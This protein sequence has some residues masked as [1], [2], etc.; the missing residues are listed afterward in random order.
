LKYKEQTHGKA[1]EPPVTIN[2]VPKTR[3]MEETFIDVPKQRLSMHVPQAND[4]QLWLEPGGTKPISSYN[5]KARKS[6]DP[7]L[8]GII[9][10]RQKNVDP[11]VDISKRRM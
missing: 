8:G 3:A 6:E 10:E 2:K 9:S 4:S 5:I 11:W 1:M 7:I